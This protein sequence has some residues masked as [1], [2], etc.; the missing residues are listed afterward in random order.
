MENKTS[1]LDES[2]PITIPDHI[3]TPLLLLLNP[4]T[5]YLQSLIETS[6]TNDGRKT[7]ASSNTLPSLLTLIES[8]HHHLLLS[9]KLLR[10]LCAGEITNQDSFIDLHGVQILLSSLLNSSNGDAMIVRMGLQVLANVSLAGERHQLSIWAKF[11][12]N[13]FM[14]ILKKHSSDKAVSDVLCMILYTCFDGCS[15]QVVAKQ[16]C[17]DSGLVLLAQIVSTVTAVGVGDDWFKILMSRI[18]I[19]EGHLGLLF[20]KLGY[21]NDNLEGVSSFTQE[22]AFLLKIASEIVNDRLKELT[23]CSGFALFVLGEFK[24]SVGILDSLIRMDSALPTG[25]AP[26]DVLGYSLTLLRDI[27]A[28]GDLEEVSDILLSSGLLDLLLKILR[29]LEP[30]EIIRKCAQQSENSEQGISTPFKPCPYKGFRRDIVSVIGN[31]AYHR[32][33]VQDEVREKDGILLML[34]Q[35]VIDEDNPYLR[36]WGIWCAKNLLE[37]NEKN[38]KFVSDLEIRG[39]VDVPELVRLGLR[40]E[41]DPN[42]RRPKLVNVS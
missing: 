22:Q 9:L 41:V 32:K 42:T 39:S 2:P 10:N 11:F 28:R 20:A 17:T 24:K 14:E 40:V 13:G 26:V 12:P 3:N 33:S 19:D 27:C 29:K 21:E 8:N 31:C 37:G 23:I 30:P 6:K 4:S 15:D 7:L 36:E 35:C 18:C 38:Q 5:E 1:P 34:Q 16:L 25:N